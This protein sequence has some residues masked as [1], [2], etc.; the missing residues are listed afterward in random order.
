VAE[1]AEYDALGWVYEARAAANPAA[2][3]S[4]RYYGALCGDCPGPVLEL[5]VGTGRVALAAAR[6]GARVTG[7]DCSRA[8][9]AIC[10]AQARAENLTD[11]VC[12]VR[13]DVRNLPLSEGGFAL[14]VFPF[15]GIGHLLDDADRLRLFAEV[16]RVLLPGGRFVF[17]HYLFDT[18]W[19]DAVE[20]VPQPAGRVATPAGPAAILDTYWFDRPRQRLRCR[21]DV[22]IRDGTRL[23]RSYLSFSWTGPEAMGALI[24]A[25]RLRVEA[26]Y[27]DYGHG[28]LTAD[29]SQQLWHV[30]KEP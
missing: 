26:V 24:E 8:M 22:A 6:R 12:L 5:G 27:G 7:V 17:D 16:R 13:A 18:A 23:G 20:G 2:K 25:S 21:I 9:L 29:A 1:T 4:W 10:R 15:R 3:P 14:V 11:R 28:G 30:R 19:A